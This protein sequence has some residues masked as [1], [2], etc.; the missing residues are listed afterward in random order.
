VS[1]KPMSFDSRFEYAEGLEDRGEHEKALAEWR[2][3][4]SDHPDAGVFCRLGGIA[5]EMGRVDEAEEA[6]R[7]AIQLDDQC[8]TGHV[9]LAL[10]LLDQ[11]RFENAERHLRK[12]LKHEKSASAYCILGT[13]LSALDREQEAFNCFRAALAIDPEY[14]EAHYNLAV[15]E[16]ENDPLLAEGHLSKA[17]E[18]DPDYSAAHRELGW[19]LSGLGQDARAEYHLRRAVELDGNDAWA[20]IYLGNLLW[21]RG[22][23]APAVSEFKQAAQLRPDRAYPVW[24][25]ANLYEN[26]HEWEKAEAL[27][28]RAVELEPDDAIAHMNFGRMLKARGDASRAISHLERALSIDPSY[29]A[30]RDLLASLK[31]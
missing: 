31:K 10:I 24:S 17:I 2:Q 15:G 19:V 20:R 8:A 11:H 25:L 30:A 13:V 16:E 22:D 4:A 27:Y 12:A 26:Q 3:L 18:Y 28:A 5:K 29:V 9:N 14:E 23:V 7:S 6:F 1:E 21:K